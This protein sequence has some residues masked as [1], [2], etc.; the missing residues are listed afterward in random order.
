MA[1]GG[2]NKDVKLGF[3]GRVSR[4]LLEARGFL[5]SKIST[6]L[7]GV[8]RSGNMSSFHCIISIA[9]VYL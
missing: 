2:D 4:S 3:R 8:L 1:D 9:V 6:Y 5:V 7:I